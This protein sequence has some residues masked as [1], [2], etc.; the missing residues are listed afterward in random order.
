M[1]SQ[2]LHN[3]LVIDDNPDSIQSL[4]DLLDSNDYNIMAVH[5]GEEGF[6]V[7]LNEPEKF[8]AVIIG[9]S[10]GNITS[11]KLLHLIN[12]S[13]NIKFVPVIMEA[14]AGSFEEMEAYVRAGAR[15]YIQ[16]PLDKKILPQIIA[17][18]IRDQMRY[19]ATQKLVLESKPIGHT[20]VRAEF[21]IKTLEEAQLV[22]NLMAGECPNPRLA[23]VGITEML[24]N[25]I[26]HGNLEISYT[27]KTKLHENEAWLEEILR[28]SKLPKYKDR[29][30]TVKFEKT[31]SHITI[32]IIDQGKGFNWREYQNLDTKRVFDN[33]GRGIVMARSLAFESLIYHDNGNDVECIIPLN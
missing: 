9:K 16:L 5:N 22:G 20:L 12:A 3:I 24:I 4:R 19:T 15:Y 28:R 2:Q 13:C 31:A 1:S 23:A 21:S 11:I 29:T 18:A 14:S 30:V 33:H 26:E 8:S 25:A 7:L 27:E 32:R 17:T 6:K 10:I